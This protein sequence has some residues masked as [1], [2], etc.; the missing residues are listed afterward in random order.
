MSKT[1]DER[2]VSMQFDNKHFESNV[3]T[4]LS[5]LDKLKQRLNLTGAAKGFDN[6]SAAARNVNMSGLGTA[7]ETVHAKFSALEV[8]GV[9]AL[10]NITN[11][12]VNAG[13]RIVSALTI[14]PVKTGFSEYETKINAI[15]TIMSNTASKGT[16]MED[17][18]RV[19]GELNTYAD[20]TI[21]NFSEM[22]RNIGT[23]TAAGVGLEESAA[24][25][26]GIANLAAASG[27]NSQQASTAMYQL[28]QALAAGTV[29]LMDWN[30]VVNAGMGGEKFQLALKETARE[31]GVAVDEIIKEQGS[32]RD[33]LSQGWITADI[34]NTTL[35]KFTIEGAKEYA[36]SMVKSGKYTREQADALLKEAQAMD[37]AATKV[38]T[39]TQLW[40]TM[41]ESVQSGWGQTWELL[42]GNF[43]EA[44][45]FLSGLS[46]K[47]GGIIEMF[48][49][50][51][52]K[53]LGGALS[54]NWDKLIEKV[55]AAG[56]ET[57]TFTERLQSVANTEL[58]TDKVD[59]LIEKY[60]SLGK[61]FQAGAIDSGI[62]RKAIS[63]L[64][65]ANEELTESTEKLGTYTVVKG[66][67]LTKIARKYGTTWKELYKLNQDIIKDPNLIYPNQVLELGEAYSEQAKQLTKL[68]DAQLKSAGYSDK[69]IAAFRELQAEANKSGSS[70]DELINNITKASGRELMLESITN[71]IDS[72]IEA[73][74]ALGQAWRKT[75][76]P[77]LTSTRLYG[78]IEAFHK[79]S[80]S[81]RLVDEETGD[82]N[83][84]GKKLMR[85]FEGIFAILDIVLLIVG[86][87]IKIVFKMVSQLLGV[88]D[89]NVL[90]LTS[91]IA[92]G[93]VK[94]RDWLD[95]VLDFSKVFEKIA[96][97]ISG[98]VDSVKEWFKSLKESE[99]LPRDIARGIAN[100]FGNAL[101][102]IK[103]IF[104][105]I[106]NIV[107]GGFDNVSD[108]MVGTFAQK[109]W[110]GIKIVGQVLA[111]LGKII[112]EKVNGILVEHGFNEIPADMFSG[113]LKGIW[114]GIKKVGAAMFEFAM[115]VIEKVK[116]VLGIHL[117][118][119]EFAELGRN[120]IQGFIN[121]ITEMCG[122]VWELLKSIGLKAIEIIQ[123][124]DLGTVIAG[125]I[126]I[127]MVIAAIN[128]ASAIKNFSEPFGELGDLFESFQGVCK[129]FSTKLKDVA[130]ALLIMAGALIALTYFYRDNGAD[131]WMAVLVMGALAA[132]LLGLAFAVDKMGSASAK[133]D[134]KGF[135]FDGLKTGMIGIGIALLALAATV[136]IL[137]ELEPEE[138]KQGFKGLAGAIVA[139]GLVI[140]AY[141]LLVKGK[142]A[143]NADKFGKLLLKM[144]IAL[145]LMVGVI[146]L[147]A[148]LDDDTLT[149]GAK[150]VGGFLG[151]AILL[152]VAA[153][154]G[155]KNADKIGKSM[156]KI[157]LALLLGVAVV[158]LTT[159]LTVEEMA[160]SLWF[161]G[162]FLAF[163]LGL[164]LIT[165]L[166]GNVGKMGT[167]MLAISASLLILV[168]VIA[169]IALIPTDK[170]LPALA[171]V[172]TL[173]LV[174]GM[175]LYAIKDSENIGKMAGTL[176]ALSVAMA[177]LAIIVIAF[178][179]MDPLALAQGV[180]AV[181]ALAG[182]I[183]LMLVATKN[184]K[185]CKANLIVMTV[186]I[187]LMAGAIIALSFLDPTNVITATACMAALMGMFALLIKVAGKV[188]GAIGVLVVMTVAIGIMGAVLYLLGDIPIQSSLGNAAALT[189]LMAA[190]TG[191]L[192]ILGKFSKIVNKA[193]KGVTG[194]LALSASLI[195][196]AISLK[197]L[198]NVDNA[199]SSAVALTILMAAMTG[200]LIILGSFSNLISKALIGVVALTAMAIPLLA[201]VGILALMQNI[202]NAANNIK[203][204]AMMTAILT[205]ML[206][207]LTIIGVFAAAALIG[208]L[209]LTAMAIPLLAFVGVLALMQNIQNAAQNVELLTHLMTTIGDVLFKLSLVAPL[210]AIGVAAL[211]AL[212]GL[213]LALGVLAVA[214]GALVTEF[215]QL[216]TFLDT[217]IPIMEQ[218][219]GGLG[220]IIGKFIAS[221]AGEVLTILPQLGASLSMF[222]TNLTPF[223]V[224]AKMID[225]QVL[226]GVGIL[227][228]S[229]LVLTVADFIN[230]LLD[231]VTVGRSLP[232]LGTELS[233]FMSNASPFIKEASALDPNMLTGVKLLAETV[234]ILTA[235]D[236]LNGLTSWL[237]GGS[238]LADFGAQLPG[239]G[240]AINGFVSNVGSC[241][242]EQVATATCAANIIKTLASAAQE[243]PNTGGLLAELIGD[244]P[245]DKFAEGLPKVGSGRAGFMANVGTCSEEHI[246]TA[247]AAAEIIK[248]MASAAKEIPNTGGLLADLIGD[249]PL[250]KFADGLPKVGSGIAG[251]M[252]NVGA[253][254]EAQINTATAGADIIKILAA[255]AQE[256]P[257]TGGLLA[258]LV[259]DNDLAKFASGLPKVG[260]GIKGFMTNIG[261]CSESEI[262][263]TKA[264]ATVIEALAKASQN[265]PNSGGLLAKLVGDNDLSTFASELPNV[266]DG[267]RGFMDSIGTMGDSQLTS[268]YAAVKSIEAFT[269]LAQYDLGSVGKKL[270][271]FGDKIVDFGGD[272]KK[273][274][275]KVAE[276]GYGSIINA[277]T[278]L[279]NIVNFAK[280]ISG[281]ANMS[282]L[283]YSLKELG[284]SGV[285]SF[286]TEFTSESLNADLK[287]AGVK[288]IESFIA[289]INSKIK[290]AKDKAGELAAETA[291]VLYE[292]KY[293]NRF[294]RA[295]HSLVSG[296][297]EG[298]DER[299]YK[300]EAKAAAMASAAYEAAKE[301]LDINSPS[302]IFRAL[303]TSVPEGFAMGIDKMSN[304]VDGSAVSMADRAINNVKNTISRIADIVNTD[305][306]S[307]PTIR[308]VLDLTDVSSG[309]GS[310]NSMLDLKP[311]LG[312]TSNIRAINTMMHRN[313]QNGVNSD[314]VSAIDK[315]RKDLG[316]VGSTSYNIEGISYSGDADVED[317][318][319]TIIRAARVERRS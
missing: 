130:I 53:L 283:S 154:I 20:K 189:I 36:E 318:L 82:F 10:A 47:F 316:N 220:S 24:A 306:D 100:G 60:G 281:T 270:S 67:N 194:L 236:I 169:L 197:M 19:I 146:K 147:V 65:G 131:M 1:I 309:V 107:T 315:L 16:T 185:D 159:K 138:I 198:S 135:S 205:V 308:P 22:T 182:I 42:I 317:A 300:A 249:N 201:F 232:D 200:V 287:Q 157:A 233:K 229:I 87:P 239:L 212:S 273:F 129:S 30:S 191:V 7:V 5:T 225:E 292:T 299:I 34:L 118:S 113:F 319:R 58:G 32:F 274:S 163:V 137:G 110:N 235:A 314:V 79:F 290:S 95:S 80:S 173:V 175:L 161:L 40:D 190:M 160:H 84:N 14:D 39:F 193:M 264:A 176:T 144:S 103:S 125:V 243:I 211:T 57:E 106:G 218:L 64:T 179:L 128:I 167:A 132:I 89:L 73:C 307:Q 271:G 123:N 226:S 38:K 280:S 108:S 166:V 248:T 206:I 213:M 215:P 115:M 93:I 27:S 72:I 25:I 41:K 90:D 227:T 102:F 165:R 54:S 288:L 15:Q 275:E 88:L 164:A 196:V 296:F 126:G 119:T 172:V 241:S 81:L 77:I 304:M 257:N 188:S 255:A 204:L 149:K 56:L 254:G 289:G 148:K 208:V 31:H 203:A 55:N 199:I 13:K 184:A 101:K 140:A 114:E 75:F 68:S 21:Y 291:L 121:G 133:I 136:K 48:S 98:A 44:K 259:G 256:I 9:T 282:S 276:I 263:T 245:L 134:K 222:M 242:E 91:A 302:K 66:D 223:I 284:E 29:K 124:L 63:L 192:L 109:L 156:L 312:M 277:V 272:I 285:T 293:Y 99:N 92:D 70:I 51:R 267:I 145:L 216:Q 71:V 310:I 177:I 178:S 186:A 246:N 18:T 265:V 111:E 6:I 3:Q 258:S 2:V 94:F 162:G 195:L 268:V 50:K 301:E 202:Q 12:A 207:P 250:D 221:L 43:E 62:I 244:N 170:M 286:V 168:G 260:S 152:G 171:A 153:R 209:A 143:Q 59:E 142:A 219:A 217:G 183:A 78:I 247:T 127:G 45:E 74:K 279:Q 105:N 297:V 230:G 23:F 180:L 141:G 49:D 150:F 46:E 37:E 262:A 181:G 96:P 85:T 17:V 122:I 174:M 234:L 238:S 294:K 303:G 214:I 83:E 155:G 278:S 252:A 261:A 313:G 158:K 295:G 151:F 298:I 237:T 311:S 97:A 35:R 228:A 61:A 33:S 52:N 28:S 104:T 251:F 253:C 69:Q 117:P 86:G 120:T 224:G 269:G 112:L 305:I 11:S 116:S 231:F 210:A 4:S 76:D 266:G 240:T 139:L 8:M 187:A 26:Q